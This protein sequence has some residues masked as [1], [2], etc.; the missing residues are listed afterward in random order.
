M[1]KSDSIKNLAKALVLFQVKVDNIKK[2]A[3]NPFFKSKYASLSN[4]LDSIKEPLTESGLTVIQLPTD[5]HELTTIVMHESG[6]YISSTFKMAPVK[7]DPQGLGSVISYQRR[8]SLSAA[9]LLNVEDDDA[10]HAT[11][12]GSTPKEAEDNKPWLNKDTKEFNGAVDK[13]KAGTTTLDKIRQFYKVS[14]AV[15]TELINLSK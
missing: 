5:E 2:D 7:N 15:E 9:L 12:G 10:N 1:Q 3:S 8:Y 14:K 11:H 13:L 6:E 4:I